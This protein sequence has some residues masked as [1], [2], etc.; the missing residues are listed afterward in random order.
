MP[1]LAVNGIE[2]YYE[3]HGSGD[4]L[5]LIG[6]LGLAVP[7]IQPLIHALSAGSRVIALDN[8]GAGGS[9][10]PQGPYTIEQ[11]AEDAAE[12]MARLGLPRAHVLGISMGGRIAMTLALDHPGLVDRLV[13]VSTGPRTGGRGRVR[14]GLAVS[15]LPVLRGKDPQPRHALHAQFEASS[16]FDCTGRL[17][18][19]TRPT[20]IVH[21]RSDRIAPVALAEEMHARIP[22]ARLE[23]LSGGH[24]IALLPQRRDQFTAAV[25]EFLAPGPQ[26]QPLAAG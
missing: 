20:L 1:L 6:G 24:L 11:M 9:S 17:A 21:G 2:L 16:H 3:S 4:P 25:R 13:L 19:I 7:E 10:K 5:V 18:G 14:L 8:R 12:L 23:L 15:R 26:V 22:G